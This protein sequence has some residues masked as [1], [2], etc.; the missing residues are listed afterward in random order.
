MLTQLFRLVRFG[1]L[2]GHQD[3]EVV[4]QK[5]KTKT[6]ILTCYGAEGRKLLSCSNNVCVQN[7]D[8]LQAR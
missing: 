6:K 2:S 5:I 7:M 3:H 4:R 8:L 1:S